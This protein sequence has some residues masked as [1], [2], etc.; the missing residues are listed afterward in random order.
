MSEGGQLDRLLWLS[1]SGRTGTH[2]RTSVAA[3][4]VPQPKLSGCE[5]IVDFAATIIR[6][7]M[8]DDID[9]MSFEVDHIYAIA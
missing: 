7:K 9:V 6:P 4:F 3:D 2:K 5:L 1:S 8:G